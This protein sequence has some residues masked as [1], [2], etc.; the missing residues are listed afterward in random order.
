M[1]L[2]LTAPQR[3]AIMAKDA[4]PLFKFSSDEFQET[5]DSLLRPAVLVEIG[6]ADYPPIAQNVEEP[7][8]EYS[9]TVI[10]MKYGQ[11]ARS[12]AETQLRVLV[13]AL[14]TYFFT[15][16]QLQFTNDRSLEAA[17]LGPLLGVKW[18]RLYRRELV[19]TVTRS[20]G[21]GAFWGSTLNVRITAQVLAHEV[22][23]GG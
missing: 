16:T 7:T 17:P 3:L 9:L 4:S 22:L 15:R 18:A 21:D 12:E 14:I 23:V 13:D 10:G 6:A 5:L 1:T 19:T 11:G 8:E 2:L 20:E